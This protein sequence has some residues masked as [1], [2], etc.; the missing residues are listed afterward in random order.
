MA[1][2][3][4]SP[5]PLSMQKVKSII[6]ATIVR[7]A[8]STCGTARQRGADGGP[9][10]IAGSPLVTGKELAK[11]RLKVV[12]TFTTPG[13]RAG[14]DRGGRGVG[15]VARPHLWHTVAAPST[16]AGPRTHPPPGPTALDRMAVWG[17]V[18]QGRF[19]AHNNNQTPLGDPAHTS[20]GHW[21]TGG[22][23]T[24]LC[25]PALPMPSRSRARGNVV[26]QLAVRAQLA[27]RPRPVSAAGGS[28]G[29]ATRRQQAARYFV[30]VRPECLTP[31]GYVRPAYLDE[32]R[33]RHRRRGLTEL[34]TGVHWGGGE[35]RGRLDGRPHAGRE[36]KALS[37]SK[38]LGARSHR[39]S[40]TLPSAL[41]P[42]IWPRK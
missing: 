13:G 22:Q 36:G 26:Q 30:V 28:R 27:D 41:H 11:A 18:W 23:P 15:Q 38:A 19:M 10:G 33:E 4:V 1:C 20:A 40:T 16:R 34:R 8:T 24:R 42:A 17:A 9:V 37:N 3:P 2:I 31:A 39:C 7:A 21:L 5:L 14:P 12:I 29:A 32:V 35:E 6:K 25:T